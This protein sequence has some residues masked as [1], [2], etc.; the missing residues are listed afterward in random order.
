[1]G[2]SMK[3]CCFIVENSSWPFQISALNLVGLIP[4][5]NTGVG[6]GCCKRN[7]GIGILEEIRNWAE[8]SIFP[9]NRQHH[10]FPT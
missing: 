6:D 3:S 8:S 7:A 2:G 1:M 10:S 4:C 9:K 5:W